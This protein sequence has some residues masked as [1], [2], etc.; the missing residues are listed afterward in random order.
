MLF[1]INQF[2]GGSG[3]GVIHSAMIVALDSIIQVTG[4]S[5]IVSPILET[6]EYADK[7]RHRWKAWNAGGNKKGSVKTEPF[8]L[9]V[10]GTK[11]L[12]PS[13]SGVTGRRSN[14]TELRPRN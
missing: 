10:A 9:K 11:G 12:E 5:N 4:G 8:L 14:Q 3:L 2:P 1:G 13:T 6:F 7:I